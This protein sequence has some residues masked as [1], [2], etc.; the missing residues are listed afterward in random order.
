[1]RDEYVQDKWYEVRESFYLT[2]LPLYIAVVVGLL[3][4]R[5]KTKMLVHQVR[6]ILLFSTTGTEIPTAAQLQ[7]NWYNTFF[8]YVVIVTVAAIAFVSNFILS[9]C[10]FAVH[11]TSKIK[12]ITLLTYEISLNCTHPVTVS[13]CGFRLPTVTFRT[14]AWGLHRKTWKLGKN[15]SGAANATFD[16]KLNLLLQSNIQGLGDLRVIDGNVIIFVSIIY[17]HKMAQISAK[18][19]KNKKTKVYRLQ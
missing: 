15:P 2:Y 3:H 14:P 7:P 10:A 18:K 1:M 13:V 5:T 19:K 11:Q 17:L 16:V 12:L 9:L 8:L 4:A 6:R